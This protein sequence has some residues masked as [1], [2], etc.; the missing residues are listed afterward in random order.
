MSRT[1]LD[2]HQRKPDARLWSSPTEERRTAGRANIPR[3]I[4]VAWSGHDV[5]Q[6]IDRDDR[7]PRA[8]WLAGLTSGNS[9]HVLRTDRQALT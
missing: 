5:A 3:P 1:T 8:P 4:G 7:D 2:R 9:G 6:T